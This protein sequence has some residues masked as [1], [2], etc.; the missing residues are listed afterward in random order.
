MPIT[1][2]AGGAVSF[3]GP[4]AVSVFAMLALASG[5][6]LYAK[7]GMKPNRAYT[8]SRMLAAAEQYTGLKFKRGE[9]E[10]AAQALTLAAE[11]TRDEMNRQGL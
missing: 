2:S 11:T 9:Y 10:K 3:D 5:L 4:V 1:K 8:P 6:R 7:T